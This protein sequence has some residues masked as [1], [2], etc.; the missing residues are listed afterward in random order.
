M[1]REASSP[2][3]RQKINFLILYLHFILKSFL[4]INCDDSMLIVQN[5]RRRKVI[6]ERVQP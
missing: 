5:T 3:E 1:K 4:C 2:D 6:K